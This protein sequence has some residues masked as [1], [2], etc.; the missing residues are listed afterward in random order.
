MAAEPE[1]RR[2]RY[3]EDERVSETSKFQ[4]TRRGAIGSSI[5][6]GLASAMPLHAAA[7]SALTASI[8]AGKMGP[9]INDYLFG[10]FTEHIGNTINYSLWSEVLEDRK[11]FYP[12]VSELRKQP[13]SM[14][15]R[16]MPAP[17]QWVPIGSDADIT[18]DTTAPYV[19]DH[20]PVVHLAGSS[21]RGIAQGNL[22]LANKDYVGR[23]VVA[24][25]PGV[26][27]TATLIWGSGAGDRQ[28]VSIAAGK[29]WAKVPFKFTCRT[30]TTSGRLE[31]AGKGKGT[32]KVGAVSLMPADNIKGFRADTMAAMKEL[33]CKILRTPGGN[34]VSSYDW[35]DTIGDPDKRPP[36]MDPSWHMV[37]PNDVGVDELLQMCQD[38]LGVEPYWCLNTGFGEPRSGAELVEYV[39]GAATTEWGAKRA[40]NG[41]PAPYKVHYWN[42]GNEM[43]GNWQLGHMALEQYTAKHN[44]F[45]DAIRKVDPSV[46]IIVPGGFVDEMTYGQGIIIDSG[47]RLVEYGSSRDWAGGMLKNSWGKFDALATHAYQAEYKHFN[48]Y[49]GKNEDV[50]QTLVEWAQAPA[51][52]IGTMTDCWEE[53]KKRFPALKDGKV[54]VYFDEWA[55]HFMPDYKGCLAI[56]RTLQEFF[57]HTDFVDMS[58]FTMAMSWLAYD[59]IHSTISASGRVFQLYNKHFGRIPV[60]V[61]GNSPT[62][63]PK[64][65]VGG[66][67]PKVNT[68]SPT[69]P[70]DV[71]AALSTDKTKLVVAIVNADEAA[72][73]LD[74]SLEHLKPA[75][76]GKTYALKS[77]HGLEGINQLG[78]AP[79]VTIVEGTFD[80]TAKTITAEPMSI[81]LYEYALA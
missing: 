14:G 30:D 18:M 77:T 33:D 5:A 72:H 38:I 12:V 11:F 47:S 48:F 41:H 53:Y 51:N 19:G 60:E 35:K 39:N 40:A 66:D 6:L 25:D 32:F 13:R 46:F 15:D 4:M 76:Q 2:R 44:M 31:I 70:L 26:A 43:Y 57:R 49:T 73:T 36:R 59:R 22:S 27:I 80:A 10:G 81:V 68:G 21:P 79:E 24:A 63:P 45:A 50:K 75:A 64:Y 17:G 74:L 69:H 9:P 1:R 55:Y 67:Q 71:S 37:Q 20:S 62:P 23:I 28:T 78:K 16:T 8:N 52:R 34:Y 56:A 29:E 3:W 54:R 42:V 61:T 65:P 58:A 7:A